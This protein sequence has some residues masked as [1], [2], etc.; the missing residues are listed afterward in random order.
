MKERE[1]SEGERREREMRVRETRR[2]A[3]CEVG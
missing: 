2:G 3:S 1:E